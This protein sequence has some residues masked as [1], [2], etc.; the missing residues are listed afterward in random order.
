MFSFIASLAPTAK[1]LPSP[2]TDTEDPKRER[3]I[4][5][6][7]ESDMTYG[8]DNSSSEDDDNAVSFIAMV[9]LAAV[10][11]IATVPFIVRVSFS[12]VWPINDDDDV[13]DG[14]TVGA[15]DDVGPTDNVEFGMSVELNDDVGSMLPPS[16]VEGTLPDVVGDAVRVGPT[17]PAGM[18]LPEGDLENVGPT[19]PV[20]MSTT[21][22][23]RDDVGSM[24]PPPLVEGE[25]PDVDGDIDIL[26][27]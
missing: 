20:G 13:G 22:G 14:V 8:D 1:M 9:E 12:A 16:F 2:D 7:M 17:L 6:S 4:L 27:P 19:L 11:F 3:Y 18:T 15:A 21:E 26:G 10:A 5:L 24:L 23:D 25:L